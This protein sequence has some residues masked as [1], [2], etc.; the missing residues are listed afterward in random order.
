MFY[1]SRQE[2]L[3]SQ[4]REECAN[5]LVVVVCPSTIIHLQIKWIVST[6]LHVFSQFGIIQP[7]TVQK[8]CDEF[9]KVINSSG[10]F[11]IGFQRELGLGIQCLTLE[12]NISH[13]S[14][15]IFYDEKANNNSAKS[16]S[17]KS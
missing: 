2:P 15:M 9:G 5:K 3:L 7:K 1:K 10:A 16:Q 11:N 4:H 13:K 14:N 12:V 6:S 8:F 17:F